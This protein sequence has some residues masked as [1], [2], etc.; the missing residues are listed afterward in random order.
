MEQNMPADLPSFRSL[1]GEL[2][3]YLG[4]NA[5]EE[6]LLPWV[7]LGQEA[8]GVLGQYGGAAA[9]TWRADDPDPCSGGDRH[10]TTPAWS[11]STPSRG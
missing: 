11:T 10:A 2:N 6:I 9:M 4:A 3:G 1:Y 8:M 5:Y 7:P